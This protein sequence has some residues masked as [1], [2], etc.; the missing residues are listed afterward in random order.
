MICI[1]SPHNKIEHSDDCQYSQKNITLMHLI[2]QLT[3]SEANEN[4]E[5]DKHAHAYAKDHCSNQVTNFSKF[6]RS[7]SQ[8]I[9]FFFN[10]WRVR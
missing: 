5:H 2:L 1:H 4:V 6:K 7:F 9:F 3:E 10:F 8:P